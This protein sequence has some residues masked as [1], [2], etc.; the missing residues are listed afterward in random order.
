VRPGLAIAAAVV[1]AEGAALLLRPRSGVIAP[2]DVKAE[3]YFSPD[4]IERAVDFRGPQLA[5]YGLRVAIE[6]G[7]LAY[8]VRRPPRWL[9]RARRPVLT[10]AAAG[11]A[12][13]VA[14]N[15]AA[16]PVAAV[17]R[18]RAMDVGLVTQSWIGWVGDL[19]K[20]WTIGAVFAAAGAT[21]AIVLLRR[22]PRRWWL[23]AA[24]VVVAFGVITTYAGPVVLDPLFNTFK[25]LPPGQLRED[26]LGLAAR[27]E[28]DVGDVLV[29]DASRRTTAAN[30]Y[31]TGLGHTKRVVLYDTLLTGFEPEEIRVVVAHELAHVHYR[32]VSHG[33]LYLLIVA[34]AG[35]FAA[36]ALTD[37][38]RG[39]RS[40]AEAIPALALS[41]AIVVPIVTTISNGLSRRVEARADS[42]A[43][44]T[45]G[46]PQSFI[47]FERRITVRNVSNPDPPRWQVW[48][49]ATHPPGVERIGAAV[50]FREGPSPRRTR[51]G[52]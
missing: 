29:M 35:M 49:L 7:V 25:P 42:Y 39:G 3:A 19:A 17:M 8:V 50:S 22:F 5:L 2:A 32:D 45:T 51:A 18:Q 44:R 4:E 15:V 11:A 9:R 10:G 34:P 23:P 31:V 30:A 28:V 33:L 47:D 48:L 36:A 16:L 24:G 40:G 13:T 38:L 41:L 1:V 12:L 43:L 21:L 14:T 52:S 46:E 6:L 26:V 20:S 37:R 27:S